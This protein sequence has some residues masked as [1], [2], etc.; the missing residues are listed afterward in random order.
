MMRRKNKVH[1]N[2]LIVTETSEYDLWLEEL[3]E[4]RQKIVCAIREN[5]ED[6]K[7]TLQD[8]LNKKEIQITLLKEE[9][10]NLKQQSI[11]CK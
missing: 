6:F 3:P 9:A 8:Q 1:E 11:K 10:R 5:F 7:K 4:D 2:N